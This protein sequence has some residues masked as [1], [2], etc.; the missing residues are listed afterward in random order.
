MEQDSP[1]RRHFCLAT[2]L[3][4]GITLLILLAVSSVLFVT[5]SSARRNTFELLADQADDT[6]DI[7]ETLIDRQIGPAV[8]A[9]SEFAAQFADDRLNLEDRRENTFHAF[10]GALSSNPEMSAILFIRADGKSI[11]VT[12]REGYPIEVPPSRRSLER[13]QFALQFA[14]SQREPFW[15]QP[16]QVPAVRQAT[17]AHVAPVWRGD[18][19]HGVVISSLSLSGISDFFEKL[20]TESELSAFILYDNDK[21]LAHSRL[22][23]A[24][25]EQPDT[26][27]GT[28]LP[29]I[30]RFPEPAFHMLRGGGDCAIALLELASDIHDAQVDDDHVILTRS[31]AQYGNENW[32]LGVVLK[33]DSVKS[34]ID[35]LEHSAYTALA[36]FALVLVASIWF[37]RHL[38]R[39]IGGLVKSA[40]ALTQLGEREVRGREG[41]LSIFQ[42][43]ARTA[44]D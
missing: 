30:D 11:T 36:I 14:A 10:S 4:G 44:N 33:R 42:L 25:F 40:A 32:T 34:E 6:L 23:E 19:L 37:A 1:K 38:N 29:S 43:N 24:N 31:S 9:A 7:L 27:E 28:P 35:R 21:V 15:A 2:I 22:I 8:Q 41:T 18:E 17:L 20:Q 12:R 3:V 16:Q 26:P 5:L 13:Q 39:Q